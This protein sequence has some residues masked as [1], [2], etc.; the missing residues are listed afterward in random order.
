MKTRS[1]HPTDFP[2]KWCFYAKFSWFILTTYNVGKK[3]N[4]ALISGRCVTG[5]LSCLIISVAER[6]SARNY[7]SIFLEGWAAVMGGKPWKTLLCDGVNPFKTASDKSFLQKHSSCCMWVDPSRRWNFI[8]LPLRP[9]QIHRLPS[10][11]KSLE[12]RHSSWENL[13]LRAGTPLRPGG[14]R[15]PPTTP[16]VR[17]WK[18]ALALWSFS[19]QTINPISW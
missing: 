11:Q 13:A 12:G 16:D 18:G 19:L 10:Q 7:S 4:Y 8:F 1:P 9:A 17:W 15:V 5:W 2:Q 3:I 6:T 14:Y